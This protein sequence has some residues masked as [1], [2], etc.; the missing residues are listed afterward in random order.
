MRVKA[1]ILKLVEMEEDKIKSIAQ[2]KELDELSKK[3]LTYDEYYGTSH[4][5]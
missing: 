2:Q 3:V 1:D 4:E 5:T